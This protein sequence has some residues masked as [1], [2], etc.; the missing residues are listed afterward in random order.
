M[1][2][3]QHKFEDDRVVVRREVYG[4]GKKNKGGASF[5]IVNMSYDNDNGGQRLKQVDNDALVRGLIRSKI[6]DTKNNGSYNILTGEERM[7]VVVPVH[8]RYNPIY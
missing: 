1:M 7:Q 5:N 3:N 4:A 8:E 6:L 2:D